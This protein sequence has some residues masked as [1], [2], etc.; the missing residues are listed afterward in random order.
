[1]IGICLKIPEIISR[2][3]RESFTAGNAKFVCTVSELPDSCSALYIRPFSAK[4][5]SKNH[6]EYWEENSFCLLT[7]HSLTLEELEH[8]SDI[9]TEKLVFQG[10]S[11]ESLDPLSRMNALK[12]LWLDTD[13][14]V[15]AEFD[16]NFPSL[17][18]LYIYDHMDSTGNISSITTLEELDL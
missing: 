14:D 6:A 5:L 17:E 16:G 7:D 8:I 12:L 10:I 1:M 11:P 2:Y 9:E 3:S 18:K 15:R 13:S 4:E